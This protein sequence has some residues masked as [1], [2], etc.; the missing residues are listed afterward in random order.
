[1]AGKSNKILLSLAAAAAAGAGIFYLLKKK[2]EEELED[3]FDED[4][5]ASS[6][7]HEEFELD[8][9]LGEVS[10]RGYVSLTPSAKDICDDAPAE[11][12]VT[13]EEALP[14]DKTSEPEAE[15]PQ[16]EDAAVSE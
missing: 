9:D 2:R 14:E 16:E 7:D 3:E 12:E 15:A 5:D 4:F 1:M 8:D 6:F 10:Q 13:A 11:D